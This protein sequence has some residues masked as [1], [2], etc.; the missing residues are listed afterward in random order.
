MLAWAEALREMRAII[1]PLT[2]PWRINCVYGPKPDAAWVS[3]FGTLSFCLA[4][5]LSA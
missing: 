3:I 2:S 1:R 4:W 5:L